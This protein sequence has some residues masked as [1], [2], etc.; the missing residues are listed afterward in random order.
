MFKSQLITTLYAR[1]SGFTLISML[2]PSLLTKCME[3]GV[4]FKVKLHVNTVEEA[5]AFDAASS[6]L[7]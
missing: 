3:L 2:L 7:L 1:D 4:Y 5:R 6:F